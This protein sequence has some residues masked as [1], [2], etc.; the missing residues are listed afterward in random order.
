MR[1]LR[2]LHDS[3]S[4]TRV[5]KVYESFLPLKSDTERSDSRLLTA[6]SSTFR[7]TRVNTRINYRSLGTSSLDVRNRGVNLFCRVSP[8]D[9]ERRDPSSAKYFIKYVS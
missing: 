1:V 3:P 7:C 6:F 9:D 5:E 8:S 4:V 2:G